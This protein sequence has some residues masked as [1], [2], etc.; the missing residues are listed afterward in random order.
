MDPNLVVRAQQGDQQAFETLAG[1]AHPRLYR[2][3][4]GVLQ[5]AHFA[6][7]ATQQALI[8]IWRYLPRLRDPLKFDGWSYKLLV[9]ACYA[10][11]KRRP[12][13]LPDTAVS[14]K[15]EP[16]ATDDFL[17]VVRR[18][19]LERAFPRLSVEQKAVIVL[20]YKL[21]LPL[22][23]VADALDVSVPATGSARS[24][25]DRCAPSAATV[26]GPSRE[27]HGRAARCPRRRTRIPRS[28]ER[29]CQHPG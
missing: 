12:D 4:L 3:A 23:Q 14:P 16:V 17:D 22:E 1:A 28:R 11:A 25:A 18:D 27:G 24:P 5:D 8:G 6:E 26:Q 20:R 9:R 15:H 10:E 29:M 13:W 7:D 19:Q 21:D 2:V